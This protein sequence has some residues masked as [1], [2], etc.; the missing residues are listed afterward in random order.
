M[1]PF[2]EKVVVSDGASWAFMNRQLNDAIPFEWHHHPEFELTLTLNSRGH[3]FIGDHIAP[4]EDGDLVLIGPSVPH[5]WQSRDKLDSGKPHVALVAQ[6]SEDW[7]AGIVGLFPELQFLPALLA[8][9]RRGVRF[10]QEAAA[11]VRARLE[12]LPEQTPADRLTALLSVLGALSQ[13]RAREALASPSPEESEPSVLLDVRFQRALDHL[14]MHYDQ[15]VDVG[16]LAG[17][18]CLSPSA[19]H[20][21]FRRQTRAT[22][23]DYLTRL[24]IGR[25]CGLLI[26]SGDSI[27]VVAQTVGYENLANF[28]RRF[29]KLKGLTPREFRAFHRG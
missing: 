21:R 18:A 15:P 28:N 17:I 23:I 24:R 8:Q 20:R 4:Y 29:R 12:G 25:A 5:S 6:F 27:A 26:E 13:D 1:K 2:F 9:S 16:T 3:R 11:G 7:A 14:H 22:P 19:F 10:S